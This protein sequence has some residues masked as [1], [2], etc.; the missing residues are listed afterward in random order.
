MS[1][2]FFSLS[3]FFPLSFFGAEEKP[4]K[5]HRNTDVERVN[6]PRVA[7]AIFAEEIPKCSASTIRHPPSQRIRIVPEDQDLKIRKL[8]QF[9]EKS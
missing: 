9:P 6:D 5:H 4:V 7:S 8:R 2:L 3:L 1:C